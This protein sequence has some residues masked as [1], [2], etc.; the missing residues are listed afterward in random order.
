MTTTRVRTTTSILLVYEAWTMLRYTDLDSSSSSIQ[1]P[2]MVCRQCMEGLIEPE[3]RMRLQSRTVT[4]V[5]SAFIDYRI[6]HSTQPVDSSK[7]SPVAVKLA[8]DSPSEFS[9]ARLFYLTHHFHQ[10]DLAVVAGHCGPWR[11]LHLPWLHSLETTATSTYITISTC[12][13]ME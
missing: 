11:P 13:T 10:R 3:R 12:K 4:C 1:H 8:S 2:H 6:N 9:H 7:G 5:R